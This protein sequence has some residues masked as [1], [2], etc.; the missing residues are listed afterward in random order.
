MGRRNSRS[1][2]EGPTSSRISGT[3]GLLDAL[4]V[5][6]ERLVELTSA[7]SGTPGW[8]NAASAAGPSFRR[9]TDGS[10]RTGA[11]TTAVEVA[12]CV[13]TP[14]RWICTWPTIRFCKRSL[15]T[16]SIPR[17]WASPL[18]R[19]DHRRRTARDDP[20]GREGP[21]ATPEV[22][23]AELRTLATPALTKMRDASEIRAELTEYL[24]NCRDTARQD[25]AEARRLLRAVLVGRFVFAG[26]PAAITGLNRESSIASRWG[27]RAAPTCSRRVRSACG[28]RLHR[29]HH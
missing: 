4:T 8:S 17:S 3:H 12:R 7:L 13:R 11:R 2:S 28:Q 29:L 15:A 23:R 18:R 25:V 16:Y 9:G 10:P 26:D 5:T 21:R 24:Q 22:I 20:T 6:V 27:H 1:L 19:G 14:W